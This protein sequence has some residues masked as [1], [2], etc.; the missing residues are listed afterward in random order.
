MHSAVPV[1]L[2]KCACTRSKTFSVRIGVSGS[3][4]RDGEFPFIVGV[5][6]II[7]QMGGGSR[8]GEEE[9]EFTSG[10]PKLHGNDNPS[11]VITYVRPYFTDYGFAY[12]LS[13][14]SF[15]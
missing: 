9:S 11:H 3:L 1:C 6:I 7:G 2:P 4:L 12:K 14:L 5:D 8:R 10:A 13:L 15:Q